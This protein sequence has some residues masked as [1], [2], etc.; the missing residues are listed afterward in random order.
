[1]G[2]SLCWTELRLR[3]R[4]LPKPATDYA[5]TP[6]FAVNTLI[7]FAWN[8]GVV[9]LNDAPDGEG[10]DPQLKAPGFM[11]RHFTVSLTNMEN[12]R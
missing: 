12:G 3:R 8:I 11:E 2:R 10:E 1:M 6:P 9:M 7:F 4:A 5:A